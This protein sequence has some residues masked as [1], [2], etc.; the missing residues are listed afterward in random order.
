VVVFVA[1]RGGPA[2]RNDHHKDDLHADY[3]V[4]APLARRGCLRSAVCATVLAPIFRRPPRNFI[5]SS[6]H[7]RRFAAR[8]VSA[9]LLA[10]MGIAA[11]GMAAAPAWAVDGVDLNVSVGTVIFGGGSTVDFANCVTAACPTTLR[12]SNT[13]TVKATQVVARIDLV[14]DAATPPLSFTAQR[15]DCTLVSA[16]TVTCPLPDI[17]AGATITPDLFAVAIEAHPVSGST[18]PIPMAA[19]V[20]VTVSAAEPD[21]NSADNT[22]T[23]GPILRKVQAGPTDWVAYAKP[24]GEQ[25][26][27]GDLL[28]ARLAAQNRGPGGMGLG[29]AITTFVAPPGTEWDLSWGD[30]SSCVEVRPKI[31]IRCTSQADF[32]PPDLNPPSYFSLRLKL[33]SVPVGDGEFRVEGMGG[34]LHPSDNVAKIVIDIPGIPRVVPSDGPSPTPGGS[35]G[36]SATGTPVAG[37]R[38][39]VTGSKTGLLAGAGALTLVLGAVLF[40]LGRRRRIP[41]ATDSQTG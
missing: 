36:T 40:L 23:S 2:A 5:V 9:A 8:L 34:E 20:R 1:G 31:E 41:Q 29:E 37:G 10:V 13:G 18:N 38:L 17:D 6:T 35:T 30:W 14:S 3:E 39:P 22:A 25:D 15:N 4:N 33:V 21:L 19:R 16:A 11:G 7:R 27:Q 26:R 32:I 28:Y 24:I 12:F